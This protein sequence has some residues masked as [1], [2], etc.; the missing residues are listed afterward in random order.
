MRDCSSRVTHYGQG[1][2]RGARVSRSVF[3]RRVTGTAGLL[4]S[5]DA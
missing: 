4:F 3:E 5:G 1:V 2:Q